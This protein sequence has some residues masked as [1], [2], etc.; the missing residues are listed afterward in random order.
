M[1]Q[2]GTAGTYIHTRLSALVFMQF[3][4]WG[5]WFVTLG[6]YL[7]RTLKLGGNEVGLVY[8][9]T[10]IASSVTPFLVGMI[11][12]KWIPAQ[13]LLAYLHLPAAAML[14]MAAGATTFSEFYAYFLPYTFLYLPT[15][16][17]STAIAFRHIAN[18]ASTYP[19]IRIWG[20]I[21]WITA[22][23]GLSW[24]GWEASPIPLRISAV[25]TA[26]H[27]LYCLTLPHT[28]PIDSS[29]GRQRW[30]NPE[31]FALFK[32][33]KFT[34]AVICLALSAIPAAYYYSFVNP[35][36]NEKGVS[37]AAAKMSLG[38]VSEMV[39]MLVLPWLTLRAGLRS[40][41]FIGYLTWGLRYIL[42]STGVEWM[43]YLAIIL[44]GT[45]F[46]FTALATQ[47]YVDGSTPSHLKSTVQ[48]FIVFLTNGLGTLIGSWIAG[49]TVAANTPADGLKNWA[50][51]WWIPA[52][53]G[54]AIAGAF[55]YFFR[56]KSKI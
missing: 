34:T 46:I 8:G 47:I 24:L 11:A 49:L 39:V 16:S 12:D 31:F 17:L 54:L 13:K 52:S 29:T 55:L 4:T 18:P 41:L 20:S 7:M 45:A 51:I 37:M 6:N 22:G 25:M 48:G 38:Q 19:W 35:Y 23:V 36:L 15:F 53:I 14:W 3:F 27:G 32:D 56:G 21:G 42:L 5:T 26:V 43:M 40:L 50:A 33:K 28:P 30:V 44:H 2:A 9:A 10:A 1:T